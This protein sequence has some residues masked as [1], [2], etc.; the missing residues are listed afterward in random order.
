[1]MLSAFVISFLALRSFWED[2]EM[3]Y[4]RWAA[5]AFIPAL[6]LLAAVCP[7]RAQDT[8]A[9]AEFQQKA[10]AW[11]ALPV[12]PALSEDVRRERVQAE[13]A[14]REKHLKSAADHYESG[15]KINPL[16]PEGHFNAGFIDAELEDYDRAIWHMR[17]YVELVPNAPDAQDVR[18]QV[19]IWQG[20]LQDMV[21]TDPATGLMWTRQDNGSD[22]D[23]YQANDYCQNLSLGGYASWRQPTVDELV[24]IYDKTQNVGGHI[25]GG[26]KL[27]TGWVWSS[28][29]SGKAWN[30]PFTAGKRYSCRFL[31]LR[32]RELRRALCVRRFEE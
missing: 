29:S 24:G 11:R 2:T 30:F 16:W 28:R 31:A 18:D 22:V 4:R 23:W 25:K 17:A 15:L 7:L 1:M 5:F 8:A 32:D 13:N 19:S 27:S 20:K 3:S 6:I 9:W 21:W 12:K 26:I 14:F 10:A